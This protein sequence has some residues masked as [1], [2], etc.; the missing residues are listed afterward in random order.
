MKTLSWQLAVGSNILGCIFISALLLLSSCADNQKRKISPAFYYWKIK[1]KPSSF[2]ESYLDSFGVKK[3]YS[4]LF[5]IDW[6]AGI[7]FPSPKSI[8]RYGSRYREG[9][10]VIPTIFIT[11]RALE[12]FPNNDEQ[13]KELATKIYDKIM[14]VNDPLNWIHSEVQFDCDWTLGTKDKYFTLLEHLVESMNY[15]GVKVSATIRLHQVKYFEKTGVPP[16]DRGMLMFYNMGDLDKVGTENSILDVEIGKSYFQNFDSYPLPL[17]VALP[18]FQWGVIF[19]DGKLVRLI[20]NLRAI[21]LKD[22]SRFEQIAENRFMV[23]S[24]TYLEGY[25]LYEGDLIRLE[26]VEQ[27]ALLESAKALSAVIESQDLTVSFYHL[28][29]L[30]LSAFPKDSLEQILDTFRK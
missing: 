11:N 3:L 1:D 15:I 26:N 22:E 27:Q 29:S 19:R 7:N 2:E 20:N 16:V 25:Y 18:I 10:E 21:D 9:V 5:D 8:A 17:D 23:V 28:D 24:S 14:E 13:L 4:K 12:N 30:S 6:D